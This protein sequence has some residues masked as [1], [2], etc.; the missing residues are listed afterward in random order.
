[1]KYLLISL[2]I[3]MGCR[4]IVL[5]QTSEHPEIARLQEQ[6]FPLDLY[7]IPKRDSIYHELFRLCYQ[8]KDYNI[9]V[10][11]MAEFGKIHIGVTPNLDTA[12]YF[13]NKAED[14]ATK[15]KLFSALAKAQ[16]FKAYYYN[17]KNDRLNSLDYIG[18]AKATASK[19][20]GPVLGSMSKENMY[21]LIGD[22]CKVL[23]LF[24]SSLYNYKVAGKIAL[25][26]Q[27]FD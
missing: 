16:L 24:D 8:Y 15:N 3:F 27:D 12:I 20:S 11:H 26:N 19:V 25:R 2:M 6:L 17:I 9:L 23:N 5:A 1:M 4:Q 21:F 18:K 14:I 22:M 10:S 13:I 7:D